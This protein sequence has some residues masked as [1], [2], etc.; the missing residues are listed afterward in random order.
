MTAIHGTIK[1][2]VRHVL[3]TRVACTI[4]E[5]NQ[6][7]S[8]DINCNAY[9]IQNVGNQAVKVNGWII[10]PG[11]NLC[12]G[13]QDDCKNSV[14]DCLRFEFFGEKLTTCIVNEPCVQ[15]LCIDAKVCNCSVCKNEN[16]V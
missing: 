14:Q 4:K 6:T 1:Y 10:P 8:I 5:N 12:I 3:S 15:V 16:N 13:S 11:G 7:K 2:G 9:I